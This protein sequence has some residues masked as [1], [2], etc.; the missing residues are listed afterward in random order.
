MRT[1]TED[2]CSCG[3][4][5]VIC[6]E[7]RTPQA[8]GPEAT[9]TGIPGPDW[10]MARELPLT[11]WERV[12]ILFGADVDVRFEAPTGRCSGACTITHTVT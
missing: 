8:Q 7:C 11:F 6:A 5:D 2:K 10:Y 1:L 3:F 4:K 12:M 9:H